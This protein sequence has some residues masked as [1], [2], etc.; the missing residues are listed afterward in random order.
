[1][2]QSQTWPF[3]GRLVAFHEESG[4]WGPEKLIKMATGHP[5]TLTA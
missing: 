5:S 1:V 4:P 2:F 3:E